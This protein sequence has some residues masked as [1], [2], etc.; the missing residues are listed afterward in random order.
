MRADKD[1]PDKEGHHYA[2]WGLIVGGVA[3]SFAVYRATSKALSKVFSAIGKTPNSPSA[4]LALT[5]APAVAP[6]PH[7]RDA[8]R[9]IE[10]VSRSEFEDRQRVGLVFV[11]SAFSAAIAA[12]VGFLF[13]YWTGGSNMLLGGTLALS[14]GGLGAALVLWAHWLMREREA[15]EPREPLPSST[16]ERE[17]ASKEFF[18]GERQIHRRKLL[19]GMTAAVLGTFAAIFI[20]LLRSFG[21]PPGPFMFPAVWKRGQ[22]LVTG[23]GTRVSMDTLEV[24]SYVTV[25]PKTA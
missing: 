6:E 19:T 17:D 11:V 1:N 7:G 20:S 12:G 22:R 24:G 16:H 4:D 3:F 18:A 2:L 15:V 13:V 10:P 9:D 14:F 21:P 23:T 5:P 8:D 25:F